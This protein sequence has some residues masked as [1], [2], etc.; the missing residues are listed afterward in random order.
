[1]ATDKSRGRDTLACGSLL[2]STLEIGVESETLRHTR[3]YRMHRVLYYDGQ[4]P[5]LSARGKEW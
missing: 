5:D 1:V 3:V 2:K 4:P